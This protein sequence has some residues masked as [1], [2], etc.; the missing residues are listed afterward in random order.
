MYIKQVGED[1]VSMQI[2]K[3]LDHYFNEQVLYEEFLKS[4][5]FIQWPTLYNDNQ[6]LYFDFILFAF[7]NSCGLQLMQKCFNIRRS[8]IH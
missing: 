5:T 7:D 4:R 2:S 1:N 8:V 3:L 6:A